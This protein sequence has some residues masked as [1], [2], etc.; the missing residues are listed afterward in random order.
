MTAKVKHF[1]SGV[2]I[3]SDFI[4]LNDADA[5]AVG[6]DRESVKAILASAI[7][8]SAEWLRAREVKATRDPSEPARLRKA[9]F[10]RQ[11]KELLARHF[12]QQRA[13]ITRYLEMGGRLPVPDYLLNDP[14][15]QAEITKLLLDAAKDGILEVTNQTG[16]GFDNTLTNK[17]AATWAARYAGELIKDIDKTTLA[18]V[19]SAISD[20]ADKPGFTIGDVIAQLPFDEARSERIAVTEITRAYAESNQIAG[21]QIAKEFEG[22]PVVKVWFTNNDDRVCPVCGPLNGKEVD[23]KSEFA[24]GIINP[25]AHP[26]CRCW[27]TTTT[28]IAK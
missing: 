6:L 13:D 25:P 8:V 15:A 23:I 19:Q 27:T 12:D 14:Q 11:L 4:A 3:S 5:E 7:S 10:D 9:R 16:L 2:P 21:E 1:S 28:K 24:S 17:D 22:V 20:F 18:T 26:N